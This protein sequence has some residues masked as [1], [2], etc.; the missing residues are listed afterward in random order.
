MDGGVGGNADD[1]PYAKLDDMWPG[2]TEEIFKFK[3]EKAREYAA[4]YNYMH[5]QTDINQ[6]MREILIDWIVEVHLK[7]HLMPETLYLA[8]SI[9]DRFLERKLVIR[10]KLQLV[11]I[12]AMLIAAKF[13]EIHPPEVKDCVYI[14]DRA[15]TRA[16]ILSM[17]V[18]ILNALKFKINAPTTYTFMSRFIKASHL[19]DPQNAKTHSCLAYYIA[20]LSLQTYEVLKVGPPCKVAAAAVH[21][22]RR[23][24]GH[25]K[26]WTPLLERCSGYEEKDLIPCIRVLERMLHLNS[27][28]SLQAVRKKYSHRDFSEVSSTPIQYFRPGSCTVECPFCDQSC[29]RDALL[30]HLHKCHPKQKLWGNVGLVAELRRFKVEEWSERQ[31]RHWRRRCA[32]FTFLIVGINSYRQEELDFLQRTAK[33]MKDRT[34]LVVSGSAMPH[35]KVSELVAPM[36]SHVHVLKRG[37]VHSQQKLSFVTGSVNEVQWERH[38]ANGPLMAITVEPLQQHKDDLSELCPWVSIRRREPYHMGWQSDHY[39][40][41]AHRLSNATPL[42]LPLLAAY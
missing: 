38:K 17:E 42:D 26:G 39:F 36:G 32:A 12:T 14:T 2:Y 13:E 4:S 21:M 20:E 27:E 19:T 7:W 41:H 37:R 11:G 6:K 34:L 5:H 22:A 31:W 33:M 18:A 9:T 25:S 3:K 35:S 40:E 23:T 1:S 28:S 24:V 30:P 15:Y 10:Q 16:Q 29:A 8:I